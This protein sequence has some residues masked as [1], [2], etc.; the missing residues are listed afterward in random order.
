MSIFI[1]LYENKI[2]FRNIKTNK[3]Y[4]IT[5]IKP[6]SMDGLLIANIDEAI[7]NIKN[8]INQ[9]CSNLNKYIVK[10]KI[11]LQP[12]KNTN[13]ISQTEINGIEETFYQSGTSELII[14]KDEN[15][16]GI[17]IKY[18]NVS[19][20]RYVKRKKYNIFDFLKEILYH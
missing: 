9:V 11:Y 2:Y 7:I 14:I 4:T 8:G 13:E 18:N 3:E 15:E 19:K 12:M 5:P 20:I 1:K 6:F 17:K 16:I 10:P